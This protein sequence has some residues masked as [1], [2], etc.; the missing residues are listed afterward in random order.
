MT[1]F[2][3]EMNHLQYL[4]CLDAKILSFH[5]RPF[6][7]KALSRFHMCTDSSQPYSFAIVTVVIPL[8]QI[9]S[10]YLFWC[11]GNFLIMIN[12]FI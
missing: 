10:R 1:I 3:L 11:Q 8:R 12:F 7:K 6:G 4:V 2:I 5:R 9:G